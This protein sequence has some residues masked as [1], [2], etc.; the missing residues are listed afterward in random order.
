[1]SAPTQPA[2]VLVE[3]GRIARSHGLKGEVRVVAFNPDSKV[4]AT[5]TSLLVKTPNGDLRRKVLAAR[6]TPQGWLVQFEGVTDRNEAERLK[7]AV[8]ALSKEELPR[9]SADEPYFFELVGLKVRSP[10]GKDLGVVKGVQ[11]YPS[12]V[13]LEVE[14]EGHIHEVPYIGAWV[15][16]IDLAAQAVTVTVESL[17]QMEF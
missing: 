2:G 10:S 8:V 14:C 9:T 15:A 4:F 1:M 5:A 3:L 17:E 12:V 13:A 7:G 6:P 11:Q 16:S